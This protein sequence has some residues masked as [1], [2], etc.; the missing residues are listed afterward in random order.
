MIIRLAALALFAVSSLAAPAR[1]DLIPEPWPAPGFKLTDQAGKPLAADDLKGKVYVADFFFTSCAGPCPLMTSKMIQLAKK[2]DHPDLRFV[3]FSVDPETDTPER[4]RSYL[5]ERQFADPRLHFLTGPRTDIY[6]VARGFKLAAIPGNAEHRI[7][8]SDRFMVVDRQGRV[9]GTYRPLDK[10]SF[11]RMLVDLPK[12]LAGTAVPPPPDDGPPA[13]RTSHGV[14]GLPEHLRFFPALNASLN[15]TAGI[16]LVIAFVLVKRRRYAA[17]AV[18][19]SIAVLCSAA[20]LACYVTFHTLKEGVLT[21]FPEHA[22]RPAYQ[23]ILLTH[24]VLAAVV[25][26]LIIMTVTRAAKRQ[27]DRHVRIARP[28]FFIWLYVSATGVLVYWMLYH[29]APRL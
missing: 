2:V 24:T 21:R 13:T 27:W 28:T 9:V 18:F 25:L 20:F 8:H 17:H 16:C 10:E 5:D 6:E 1:A 7:F 11:D 15:G 29:L 4:L 19:M 23:V 22:V 26:P 3:G 12:V 14:A